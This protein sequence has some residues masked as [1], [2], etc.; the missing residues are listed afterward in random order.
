MHQHVSD[1]VDINHTV[2][3]TDIAYMT[4]NILF[5]NTH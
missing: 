1:V 2:K 4:T 5:N 3:L